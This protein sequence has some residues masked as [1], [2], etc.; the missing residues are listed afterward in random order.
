M[1]SEELEAWLDEIEGIR[2][3]K[4]KVVVKDQEIVRDANP[5]VS[6]ADPNYRGS[7]GGVVTVR[8]ND[9]V[10][11]NMPLWEQQQAEKREARRQRRMI[12]P[13]RLGLYGPVDDD[14]DEA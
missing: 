8:R 4:P 3:P 1:T 12:D 13:A 2:P 14:D 9:F 10:K 6:T 11:I 7:D 5:Y